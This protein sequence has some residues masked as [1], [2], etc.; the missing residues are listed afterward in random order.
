MA[1]EQRHTVTW[2]DRSGPARDGKTGVGD[3]DDLPDTDDPD[4][5]ELDD[6]E[7]LD[8][9]PDDEDE[10]DEEDDDLEDLDDEDDE[11]TLWTEH[12]RERFR[13]AHAALVTTLREHGQRV[14]T[15]GGA[16]ADLPELLARNADLEDALAGYEEAL[17]DFTGTTIVWGSDYDDEDDF[18]DE[19]EEL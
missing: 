17:A 13:A 16:L 4:G 2:S 11:P 5:E 18:D 19:D 8:D 14:L 10:E 7:D 12:G 9:D 15:M 6:L 1:D 3:V